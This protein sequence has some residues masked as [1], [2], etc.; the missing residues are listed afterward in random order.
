MTAVMSLTQSARINGQDPYAYLKNILTH[1]LTHKAK[2][3]GDAI[4]TSLAI[5]QH[6]SL[7]GNS[8]VKSG[9]TRRLL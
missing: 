4:A 8:R 9:V 7:T 2:R 5:C 3:I 1:L 6:H